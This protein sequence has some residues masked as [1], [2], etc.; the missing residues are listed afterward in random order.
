MDA[1]KGIPRGRHRRNPT[2]PANMIRPSHRRSPPPIRSRDRG[3][4]PDRPRSPSLKRSRHRRRIRHASPSASAPRTRPITQLDEMAKRAS[5]DPTAIRRILRTGQSSRARS[6]PPTP[7]GD[8]APHI[9]A[10]STPL[11]GCAMFLPRSRMIGVLIALV[12]LALGGAITAN[13]AEETG[14]VSAALLLAEDLPAD[15]ASQTG[16][17]EEPAFDYDQPSFDANG[18]VDKANQVWQVPE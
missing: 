6:L 10:A 8:D 5:R 3:R 11:R 18:G 12:A 15:L 14:D 13:G 7:E 16:I 9:L 2:R 4:S 1:A 17:L